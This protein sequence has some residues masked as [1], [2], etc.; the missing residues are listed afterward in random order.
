MP[1]LSSVIRQDVVNM[2]IG[3]HSD[4]R[5]PPRNYDLE[6]DIEQTISFF[7]EKAWLHCQ[8]TAK[9][10]N[11]M[12]RWGLVFADPNHMKI[13]AKR[14]H[15]TLCDSTHKLNKWTDNLNMF[16][17]HI[18]NK[19]NIWIPG[20]HCAVE[21]ENSAVLCL[22]MECIKSW[23]LPD[24]WEPRYFLTDDSAI[25][26]KAVRATFSECSFLLCT[27]HSERTLKRRLVPMD[28]CEKSHKLL[29]YA[30]YCFTRIKCEELSTSSGGG[31]NG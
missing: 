23:C 24:V 21:R 9:D 26:Q 22:A 5:R 11:G 27:V 15:L 4:Q 8:F 20:A 10:P 25:E 2:S 28:T 1:I 16:S 3:M 14:G 18:W 30:M 29:Q 17:F 31:T 7:T 6:S 13:L 12:E 19:H